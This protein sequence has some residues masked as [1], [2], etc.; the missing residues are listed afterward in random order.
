MSGALQTLQGIEFPVTTK[1][2][3]YAMTSNSYLTMARASAIGFLP[4]SVYGGPVFRAIAVRQEF[5]KTAL[6]STLELVVSVAGLIIWG[7]GALITF[8]N[9]TALEH[10]NGQAAYSA[11]ALGGIAA[12]LSGTVSPDAGKFVGAAALVAPLALI[13]NDMQHQI[14][15]AA[16]QVAQDLTQ[17]VTDQIMDFL[18]ALVPQELTNGVAQFINAIP[19]PQRPL[20][21]QNILQQAPQE[22]RPVLQTLLNRVVN[23][24][25]AATTIA[26]PFV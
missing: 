8:G 11:A 23:R 5:L 20:V 2:S 18:P 13:W 22:M 7:V 19:A 4:D 14:Q 9:K 24:P 6:V 25:P 26:V 16:Q 12:G 1:I 17:R 21:I 10:L 3:A 15:N